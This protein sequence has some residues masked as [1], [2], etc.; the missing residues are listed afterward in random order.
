MMPEASLNQLPPVVGACFVKYENDFAFFDFN[1]PL[2]G[3]TL[4]FTVQVLSV[5]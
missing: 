1:H 5:L 2:A 4:I 3:E